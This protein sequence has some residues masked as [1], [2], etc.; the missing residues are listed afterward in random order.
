M[1][2][3]SRT[4]VR[5]PSL[6]PWTQCARGYVAWRSWSC[7]QWSETWTNQETAWQYTTFRAKETRPIKFTSPWGEGRGSVPI[8]PV[9]FPH[10]IQRCCQKL[11]EGMQ[12]AGK[13]PRGRVGSVHPPH[14]APLPTVRCQRT[15]TRFV[16]DTGAAIS[17]LPRYHWS[18]RTAVRSTAISAETASSATLPLYS[19][20]RMILQLNG[21]F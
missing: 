1:A 8:R 12:V 2:I 20:I 5:V 11:C 17:I 14:S 16:L 18:T 3:P 10:E 19:S 13:R 15:N 6:R 9:S 4:R 7:Y 21:D